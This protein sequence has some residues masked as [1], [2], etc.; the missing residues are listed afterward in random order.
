[1]N[2][3]TTRIR[4]LW[5]EELVFANSDLLKSRIRNY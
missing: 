2:L 3:K 1:M 5:S 4:S